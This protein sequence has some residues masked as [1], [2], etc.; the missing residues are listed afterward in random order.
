[1][2]HDQV[3]LIQTGYKDASLAEKA[4]SENR[5]FIQNKLSSTHGFLTISGVPPSPHHPHVAQSFASPAK[6]VLQDKYQA[7]CASCGDPG[8]MESAPI[9]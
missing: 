7:G 1:V 3:N 4:L 2:P 5:N 8:H 6:T 9:R